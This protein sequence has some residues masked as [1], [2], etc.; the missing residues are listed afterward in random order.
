M[1]EKA[2]STAVVDAKL[3]FVMYAQYHA[4]LKHQGLQ[5]H[6][7]FGKDMLTIASSSLRKT[8]SPPFVTL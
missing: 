3:R 2:S 5:L 7:G 1:D 4:L 6:Q 8:L